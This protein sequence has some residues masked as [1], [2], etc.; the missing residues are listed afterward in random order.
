M[1]TLPSMTNE[2]R[3]EN[4]EKAS[5]VR[6]RRKEIKALI[7]SGKIKASSIFN[8]DEAAVQKWRVKLVLKSIPGIGEAKALGLMRKIGISENKRV[9]GMGRRQ[10]VALLAALEGMGQ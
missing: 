10:L 9:S 6:S 3:M 4:L 5:A 1:A 7:A 2:Q 8:S